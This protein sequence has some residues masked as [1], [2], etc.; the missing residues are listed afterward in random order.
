MKRIDMKSRLLKILMGPCNFLSKKRK[1]KEIE[2]ATDFLMVKIM[3]NK[4]ISYVTF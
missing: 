1:L 4:I 2:I 3:S